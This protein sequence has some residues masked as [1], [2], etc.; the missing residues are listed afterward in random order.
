MK[1][2]SI[3]I[4]FPL[5]GVSIGAYAQSSIQ[6][7]LLTA[8]HKGI[9]N[10]TLILNDSLKTRSKSNGQF[11][12]DRLKPGQYILKTSHIG[13]R[14]SLDTL[15]LGANQTIQ[16]DVILEVDHHQLEEAQVEGLRH[17]NE[18]ELSTSLRVQTPILNLAQN[19]QVVNSDLLAK[20][21]VFNLSDGLIRNVSG[22]SRLTHWNDMYVNI[23]MR[24]SQI[25]A[26][27]NGMNVVTSFWSPLSEDMSVVERVEFVKGPAGFMMSS[28]DPAGIYNV[29]TKKPSGETKGEVNFS[30]GS[31]A[32]YRTSLDLDGQLSKDKKL[33]YRLN[34][35][36][37]TKG[38]FRPF[39]KNQ[40]LVIAPVLSY[41]LDAGTKAT[42]EYT[43]QRANMSDIGSAYVMSPFGYKSLDRHTTM[44]A[45]GLDPLHVNDHSTFITIEHELAPNWKLTG[46]GAYFTYNQTGASSWPSD[47]LPDG[48][49]IRKS[50]IWDA[51]SDMV[52]GQIF[53]NGQVK[54]GKVN[55][56]ILA[57]LDLGNKNYY[58]DWN[59]SIVLD[60]LGG[61]FDPKAPVY[62][63]DF[64]YQQFDRSQPLRSRALAGGGVMKTQYSSVYIQD[65][66]GFLDNTLRL[67]LAGRFTNMSVASWGGEPV[68][69]K[70]V[71]PRV[72]LS[73]A[74]DQA[75]SAYALYDQ[76]FIPQNGL[77]FD[78]NTVKPITGDMMELGLK[79]DWFS[80][81]LS[82]SVSAYQ[83]IK[84]N[85]ITSYGPKPEMSVEIGQKK[86][87]GI[88]FDLKGEIFHGFTAVANYAY[89]DGK[90]TK[91]ND[92][93][94]GLFVGQRLDGADKHIAN[95]WL[96]YTLL[97]GQLSG[98]SF[99]TGMTA[100][101]DRSTAFYSAEFPERNIEDYVRFDAGLAYHKDKF[102][103]TLNVMNLAD[104]YLLAG[105]SYYADK[106]NGGYFTAPVYS[107][108]TEAPRNYR[109]S[110][111]YRF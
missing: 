79:R 26:F 51:Q 23:H 31:F 25:Q 105:G 72:G 17:V 16:K 18:K 4:L 85:E 59:Q 77:L 54:T 81:R 1:N 21:Q 99:R 62:S 8:D 80:G 100:Y 36:G 33:L 2:R 95:L 11:S 109:L 3:L 15:V 104:R 74:I 58:A 22:V 102:S 106:A 88:E 27:R 48:K 14:S 28:G 67:T 96:D 30:M 63:P 66:L 39:E 47:I 90:I 24:G 55:H 83:I 98:L 92:G 52:L 61:A 46:Q 42:F 69:S 53:V 41:Q 107:W 9:S 19:V 71:T 70:K 91:I 78:G 84:N 103:V 5:V 57:G 34:I 35:A 10:I 7:R 64:G 89:T 6:G 40:R 68:V 32:S 75:T 108:Q 38:S 13:L 101:L 44:S 76:S 50:D 86:V 87:R 97:Q 37:D 110:L 56:S 82:T 60:S 43:Y 29:V 65:E 94:E 12:F 45:E 93:V 73:Y 111:G 20:Q 49:V